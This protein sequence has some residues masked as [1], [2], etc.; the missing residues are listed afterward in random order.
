MLKPQDLLVTITVLALRREQKPVTFASLAQVCG[1]SA[2]DA[3]AA[4]GRARASGFFSGTLETGGPVRANLIEFLQHGAAYVWPLER[5]EITRGI[6]TA[7]SVPAVQ[8]R[9]KLIAPASPLVWPYPGGTIRGESMVPLH[10]C[11][12]RVAAAMPFVHEVFA[13]SDLIRMR[14]SRFTALAGPALNTLL[15][16]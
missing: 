4:M 3:H 6:P 10:K 14:D 5:G 12:P 7:H 16:E 8:E 2:S 13:L 11:V 1:L 15:R 9:L